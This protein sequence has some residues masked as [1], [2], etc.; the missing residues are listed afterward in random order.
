MPAFSDMTRRAALPALGLAALAAAIFGGEGAD[1]QEGKPAI[2]E[3]KGAK[4]VLGKMTWDPNDCILTW[5]AR[6]DDGGEEKPMVEYSIDFHR[7]TMSSGGESRQFSEQERALYH[8]TFK[9]VVTLYA[10][11]STV[12]W[13]DGNG[14]EPEIKKTKGQIA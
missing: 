14:V 7:R 3:P 9:K 11:A 8:D 5:T 4:I 13:L 12:W 6:V 2:P 1:A 10:G